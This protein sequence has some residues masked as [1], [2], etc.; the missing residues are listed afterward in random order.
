MRLKVK[1]DFIKEVDR[2]K[3]LEVE[4]SLTYGLNEVKEIPEYK[5]AFRWKRGENK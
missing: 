5:I 2:N 3:R 4:Q 1:I